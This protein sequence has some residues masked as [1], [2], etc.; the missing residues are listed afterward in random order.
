MVY[1]TLNMIFF[2]FLFLAVA[3][4]WR[5]FVIFNSNKDLVETLAQWKKYPEPHGFHYVMPL[6]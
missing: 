6:R 3:L 4:A 5:L 2:L 1:H